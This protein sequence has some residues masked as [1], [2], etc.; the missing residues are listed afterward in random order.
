MKRFLLKYLWKEA[1]FFSWLVVVLL[2]STLLYCIVIIAD[3]QKNMEALM[4]LLILPIAL[5][6]IA[7]VLLADLLTRRK[8]PAQRSRLLIL[9]VVLALPFIWLVWHKYFYST[10]LYLQADVKWIMLVETKKEQPDLHRNFFLQRTRM[11]VPPDGI[12]LV[13]RL[14]RSNERMRMQ[15]INRNGIKEPYVT[16][17]STGSYASE[18][19]CSGI[20]Y[21]TVVFLV[22]EKP[23]KMSPLT[24]SVLQG[25]YINAC[26]KLK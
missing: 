23:N 12:V 11:E 26:R 20:S 9:Q 3:M 1:T 8:G 2:F 6:I 19:Q 5:G 24:D 21:S 4:G 16:E 10:T 15:V 17:Y 18:L 22:E 7:A 25:L 14:F 13:D